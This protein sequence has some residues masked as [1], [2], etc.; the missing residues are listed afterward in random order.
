MQVGGELPDVDVG[1]EGVATEG[2]FDQNARLT[3]P[4]QG[5]KLGG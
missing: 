5:A 2:E 4:L 3:N 1:R